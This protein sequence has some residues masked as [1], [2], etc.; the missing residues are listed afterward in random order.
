MLIN[1]LRGTVS[2][3]RVYIPVNTALAGFNRGTLE[4]NFP[5]IIPGAKSAEEKIPTVTVPN[6]Y[7]LPAVLILRILKARSTPL[8]TV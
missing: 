2:I 8:A 1:E 3:D 5:Y 7:G 4:I 6:F